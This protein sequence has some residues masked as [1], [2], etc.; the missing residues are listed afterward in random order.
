MVAWLDSC[1]NV[2]S[3]WSN[4]NVNLLARYMCL[5][6]SYMEYVGMV[7]EVKRKLISSIQCTS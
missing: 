1:K 4:P 3:A 2:M 6:H 7:G 5:D